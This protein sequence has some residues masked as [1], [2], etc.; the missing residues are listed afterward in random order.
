MKR[1]LLIVTSIML[2]VG[3]VSP[4]LTH[5][6]NTVPNDRAALKGL[7]Q[8]RAIFDVRLA[9]LDKLLFNLGL[10]KETWEG[11]NAQGTKPK[12]IITLRGPAVRFFTKDQITDDLKELL[13]ELKALGVRI[14]L[15]SVATRVFK[16]DNHQLVP[17][18]MLVG[19]VLTSQIAWQNKGYALITL[20]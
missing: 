18:V 8:A 12:L 2:F 6:D 9:E 15:C 5:A 10:I 7:K 11:I 20:N 14:E 13:T 16:V 3:A 1:L 19:N 17:D 4:T